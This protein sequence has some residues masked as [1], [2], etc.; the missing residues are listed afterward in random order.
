[1]IFLMEQSVYR[2]LFSADFD[3]NYWVDDALRR[4]SETRKNLRAAGNIEASVALYRP[5]KALRTLRRNA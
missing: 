2:G 4:L 5:H 3:W 1:M